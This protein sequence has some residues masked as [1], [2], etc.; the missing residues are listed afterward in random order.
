MKRSGYETCVESGSRLVRQD[1]IGGIIFF[2][3]NAFSAKV[4]LRILRDLTTPFLLLS[5]FLC[6]A[7]EKR[8]EFYENDSAVLPRP[9]YRS[10]NIRSLS[11]TACFFLLRPPPK[12]D[13]GGRILSISVPV[14]FSVP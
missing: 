2:G 7:D 13:T 1:G 4:R 5:L 3:L 14:V 8:D 9:K 11:I 12:R 10:K 6:C